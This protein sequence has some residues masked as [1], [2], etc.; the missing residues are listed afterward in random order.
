M[1][2]VASAHQTPS[3]EQADP[4]NVA[5]QWARSIYERRGWR[6]LH[7]AFEVPDDPDLYVIMT[8]E[9]GTGNG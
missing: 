3:V 6:Y 7:T 8:K 2:L 9:L 5:N 1:Q 4:A